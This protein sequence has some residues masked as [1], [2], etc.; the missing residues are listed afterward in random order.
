MYIRHESTIPILGEEVA[1]SFAE[2]EVDRYRTA[3][4]AWEYFYPKM[5]KG[6]SIAIPDY[7]SCSDIK[8]AT[9]DFLCD[10]PEKLETNGERTFIVK[11]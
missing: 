9:N 7:D 2:I 8:R 5:L 11:Q 6:G 1:F 3:M 4:A 10:K